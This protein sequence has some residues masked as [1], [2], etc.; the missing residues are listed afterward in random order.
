MKFSILHLTAALISVGLVTITYP[1]FSQQTHQYRPADGGSGRNTS[2]SNRLRPADSDSPFGRPKQ[3][4]GSRSANI[5]ISQQPPVTALTPEQGG[6][7]VREYPSFFVFIP[8][9]LETTENLS[10]EFSIIDEQDNIIYETIIQLPQQASI[11]QIDLPKTETT[12]G[13]EIN[14]TY[15]WYLAVRS[16]LETVETVLGA[17]QRVEPSSELIQASENTTSQQ[18]L[19]IYQKEGIWYETLSTLAELRQAEPDKPEL[20][21]QWKKLLESV[22]LEDIKDIPLAAIISESPQSSESKKKP[23]SSTRFRPGE[24]G[25]VGKPRSIQK[26]AGSK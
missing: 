14:Q 15:Q 16:G 25:G 4:G 12:T 6:V 5:F 22:G 23:A 2:G 13:L 17:I 18:R 20:I 9:A 8:E 26:P 10:A 3:P 21:N 24:G 11:I 19:E 1:V 7:T